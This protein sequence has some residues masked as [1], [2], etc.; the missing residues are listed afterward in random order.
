MALNWKL[1]YYTTE[2][3]D[4]SAY[5]L[6]FTSFKY[7]IDN[8]IQG[9]GPVMNVILDNSATYGPGKYKFEIGSHYILFACP[10]DGIE[11]LA[12]FRVSLTLIDYFLYKLDSKEPLKI[13]GTST[14][15]LGDET[16]TD[17]IGGGKITVKSFRNMLIPYRTKQHDADF[18]VFV[19]GGDNTNYTDAFGNSITVDNFRYESKGMLQVKR[20]NRELGEMF[21]DVSDIFNGIAQGEGFTL[22]GI[23]DKVVINK[24]FNL[25]SSSTK[26][27]D[28]KP[29]NGYLA[30][31]YSH[32]GLDG[33]G[34]LNISTYTIPTDG[35]PV[36]TDTVI[37]NTRDWDPDR[38]EPDSF[39]Y[40][41]FCDYYNNHIYLP[42]WYCAD[43]DHSIQYNTY[44]LRVTKYS[45]NDDGDITEEYDEQITGLYPQ[46]LV[47]ELR[48]G[49]GLNRYTRSG[50]TNPPFL[51]M[52]L[53]ADGDL[54]R[55]LI[56]YIALEHEHVYDL[57]RLHAGQDKWHYDYD[58][59]DIAYYYSWA[60]F[61]HEDG[62]IHVFYEKSGTDYHEIL[63]VDMPSLEATYAS[64]GTAS[65]LVSED[66]LSAG[67]RINGKWRESITLFNDMAVNHYYH[68]PQL[69]NGL[70]YKQGVQNSYI[71]AKCNYF[72]PLSTSFAVDYAGTAWDRA[73]DRALFWKT[74]TDGNPHIFTL[75]IRD[76][77]VYR[78]FYLYQPCIYAD[79]KQQFI[80][81]F[82]ASGFFYEQIDGK[83]R[84]FRI[85]GSGGNLGTFT[86]DDILFKKEIEGFSNFADKFS[87]KI[88]Q[89]R[90]EFGSGDRKKEVKTI[91]GNYG[92]VSPSQLSHY[93]DWVDRINGTEKG[94]ELNVDLDSFYDVASTYLPNL[95]ETF[96]YDSITYT[97]IQ[98]IVD[99]VNWIIKI[100]GMKEDV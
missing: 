81:A 37:K 12:D 38:D 96:T 30:V 16:M 63:R 8:R 48:N 100:T 28:A 13:G 59:E 58:L 19:K 52:H 76:Y 50:G 44:Q 67:D 14:T 95:G 29:I 82:V 41:M 53:Y 20:E 43:Y 80:D 56:D 32:L 40:W 18:D 77:Y 79:R 91:I 49:A 74:D 3:I 34:E 64:R 90:L 75:N 98:A 87:I 70:F 15:G 31:L 46:D 23:Q 4:I 78:H 7:H 21:V 85:D 89:E 10:C 69:P 39:G 99:P 36:L 68:T 92:W 83:I 9:A 72:A 25:P 47:V 65:P 24:T 22:D 61:S 2:W 84:L 1:Y 33:R 5:V 17:A 86:D 45:I 73:N 51:R 55:F 71:R 57:D 93:V 11:R 66:G 97:L 27:W 62:A 26:V 54:T 42:Y 94:M 60:V 6:E 35:S 88:L